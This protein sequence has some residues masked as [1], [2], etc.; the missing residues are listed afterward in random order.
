[1]KQ[2]SRRHSERSR[3]HPLRDGSSFGSCLRAGPNGQAASG[4]GRTGNG[5]VFTRP[6]ERKSRTFALL[7]SA[8][9]LILAKHIHSPAPGPA[10]FR[11]SGHTSGRILGSVAY[12]SR[13]SR[14]AQFRR[15]SHGSGN[16]A[17][18]GEDNSSDRSQAQ[19]RHPDL[20]DEEAFQEEM[21]GGSQ[22]GSCWSKEA[23]EAQ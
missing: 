5:T 22:G 13:P 11:P 12:A 16:S 14:A 17:R 19:R 18:S 7:A 8:H 2:N 10:R 9:L 21:R 20:L 15:S 1:M 3:C 6:T 4:K 23:A